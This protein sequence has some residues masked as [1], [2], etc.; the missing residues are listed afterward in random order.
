MGVNKPYFF[1][2]VFY[3]VFI[4]SPICLFIFFLFP[5]FFLFL[6]PFFHFLTYPRDAWVA[7]P[8]AS[9]A[10][11]S[12]FSLENLTPYNW[13]DTCHANI[14]GIHGAYMRHEALARK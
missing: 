8:G 10:F 7:F 11:P 2:F 4:F 12:G 9:L 3:F 1:I 6:F 14:F 5:F 13:H